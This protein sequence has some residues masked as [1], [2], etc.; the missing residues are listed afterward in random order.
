MSEQ[1]ASVTRL[2]GLANVADAHDLIVCDVWGVVHNGARAHVAAG[3]ALRRFRERGG[4]VVL[5]SNAPRP[6]AFVVPHLDGLGV[7]RAAWD[8]IVTSGDVTVAEIEARPGVPLHHLGPA[9]D[10]PLFEGLDAPLVS[11]AEAG[12]VVCT[13]LNDDETETAED[14]RATLLAMAARGLTM[15]CANPDLVVERGDRL[16]PCAGALAGLYETL[17]GAVV[18]AGKPHRPIYDLALRQVAERRGI[19]PPASRVLAIGDAIRTDMAGAFL[20]GFPTLF[21]ARGIHAEDC[22][23]PAGTLDEGRLESWL[24]HQQYRPQAV[25]EA[26]AW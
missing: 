5:V 23:S 25:I 18:Y 24:S 15:I 10:S 11:A 26:L 3:D 2:V 21:V 8:T 6:G 9:R 17:G 4:A 22:L 13:G 16:I 1:M 19:R 12:Y 14:Y 20:M 7:P